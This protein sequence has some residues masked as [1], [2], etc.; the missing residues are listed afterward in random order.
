[1][2]SALGSVQALLLLVL[3]LLAFALD[4][5]AFV[6]AIRQRQDAFTA[7]GKLTKKWWSLITGGAA[8]LGF[9]F[10]IAQLGNPGT[11]LVF[12]FVNIVAFVAAAVYVV[13]VRPAIKAISGGN[14]N[15]GPWGPYR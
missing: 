5:F 15:N 3:A 14:G 10:L 6:D 8:A 11:L 9:I 4:G 2:L 13:D 7:A 1:M 12:H